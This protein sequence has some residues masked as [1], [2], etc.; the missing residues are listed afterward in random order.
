[1][2][3]LRTPGKATPLLDGWRMPSGVASGRWTYPDATKRTLEDAINSMPV[4]GP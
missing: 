4:T 1:V 2:P 3:Q